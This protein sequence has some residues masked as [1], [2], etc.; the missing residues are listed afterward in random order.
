MRVLTVE[1]VLLFLD[2]LRL[3]PERRMSLLTGDLLF[4]AAQKA[5]LLE[6]GEFTEFTQRLIEL[7][8]DGQ[9]SWTNPD[10]FK[11]PDSLVSSDVLH[12]ARDFYVTPT[13]RAEARALAA[14]KAQASSPAVLGGTLVSIRL[15]R[16]AWTYDPSKPLGPSG[17][18]GQVFQGI[19]PTSQTVAVKRLHLGAKNPQREIRVAELLAGRDLQ[20]VVPVLD[21]GN[22]EASGDYFVVMAM[23]DK[24]LA[25]ELEARTAMVEEEAIQTLL[26]ITKGLLEVEDLVHRDLKPANV[27]QHQGHWKL[28]DF[29]IARLVED[30][31]SENTLR[32]FRTPPYA[33]PEQWDGL[34]ATSATDVYALGCIAYE[35]LAGQPPFEG[36]AFEDYA[37]QHRLEAAP[38]MASG[39]ARLRS[40]V[41]SMLRKAPSAR[42]PLARILK[43]LESISAEGQQ[44]PGASLL[45]EVAAKVADVDAQQDAQAATRSRAEHERQALGNEALTSLDVYLQDLTRRILDRAPGAIQAHRREVKFGQGALSWHPHPSFPIGKD[46]FPRSGWDVVAG[47]EIR[48]EQSNGPNGYRGRSSSLWYVRLPGTEGYRWVEV[49][50]MTTFAAQGPSDPPF[51]LI[52]LRDADL[53]ASNVLHNFQLATPI[54]PIDDEDFEIFCDRWLGYFALAAGGRMGYPGHLPEN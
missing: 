29:G 45:A 39:S 48:V 38:P 6:W 50:Y 42:P 47:V 26:A 12:N 41:S 24:S 40:L 17:G 3:D 36:P 31:T 21:S 30:S 27:L 19:G 22:D 7:K 53:A 44:G 8:R 14:L 49:A 25:Q 15:T 52:A 46:A 9:V 28:A 1:E 34:A 51:A 43:Q 37:R 5:G 11:S 35:L 16:W 18:F 4:R 13:G 32:N 23:A 54:R 20:W 2:E 10:Y 33:A